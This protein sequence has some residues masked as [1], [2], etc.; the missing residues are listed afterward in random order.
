MANSCQGKHGS[1]LVLEDIILAVPSCG[2]SM[3][4][5]N[6]RI[7]RLATGRQLRSNRFCCL[8][9][10]KKDEG[11]RRTG[12]GTVDGRIAW[13]KLPDSPFPFIFLIAPAK[14]QVR[15]TRNYI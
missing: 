15:I 1:H 11:P 3:G 13:Q 5:M 6:K 2:R 4:H 14:F 8:L 10:K 9:Q 12:Y 7:D